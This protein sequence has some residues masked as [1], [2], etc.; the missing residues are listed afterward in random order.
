MPGVTKFSAL[1]SGCSKLKDDC[2]ELAT[3]RWLCASCLKLWHKDTPDT[4]DGEPI[5]SHPVKNP[6][7]EVGLDGWSLDQPLDEE[8]D[9]YAYIEQ[10]ILN[11]D[12]EGKETKSKPSYRYESPTGRLPTA[13][14]YDLS[15]GRNPCREIELGEW[16]KVRHPPDPP[17]ENA[18]GERAI[19]QSSC[20]WQVEEDGALTADHVIEMMADLI[21]T[22]KDMHYWAEQCRRLLDRVERFKR[23]GGLKLSDFLHSEEEWR[24]RQKEIE[25]LQLAMGL[26]K[27]PELRKTL[28]RRVFML[29]YG[30]KPFLCRPSSRS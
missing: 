22:S 15:K 1:C 13:P 5:S 21:S 16:V 4:W 28:K 26:E 25:E 19:N 11:Y 9:S 10:Q 30:G 17:M 3:G 8:P 27:D 7:V 6:C 24:E 23:L 12:K 2:T 14:A 20:S 18:C 29:L